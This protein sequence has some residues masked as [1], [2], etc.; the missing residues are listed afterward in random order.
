MSG[1]KQMLTIYKNKKLYYKNYS[2]IR[3]TQIHCVSIPKL[4]RNGVSCLVCV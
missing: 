4:S 2:S 1:S 3:V